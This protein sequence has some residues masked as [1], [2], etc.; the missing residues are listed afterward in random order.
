MAKNRIPLS[1]IV[2]STN[3]DFKPEFENEQPINSLE[4]SEQ[5]LKVRLETK[6][7]GG[8]AVT[9]IDGFIGT[10]EDIEMLGKALK[11]HCGTGGSVKDGQILIQ[12]D[13]REKLLQYLGKKG[14]K[15][16]KKS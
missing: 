1:G 11:S 3:A 2:Y 14:Y 7:R 4:P 13:N 6:N 12:G 8:K 10:N 16:V 15:N 9:V 5:K